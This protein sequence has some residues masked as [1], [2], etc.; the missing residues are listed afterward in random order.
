MDD[1]ESDA[2]VKKNERDRNDDWWSNGDEE[3]TIQ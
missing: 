3:Q 1:R 2:V